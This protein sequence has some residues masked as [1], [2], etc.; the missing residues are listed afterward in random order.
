MSKHTFASSARAS[1]HHRRLLAALTPVAAIAIAVA[2]VLPTTPSDAAT[3]FGLGTATSFA[4]LAGSGITNPGPTTI[5]GDVGT[6]PTPA[7][8]GFGSVTLHGI[9]HADDAVTQGSKADLIGAYD[10]A[11]G[12]T[13][14]TTVPTELG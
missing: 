1:R 3:N 11:A 6:H 12:Q 4:V 5:T 2:V 8:T 7:E 13:S 14:V 9:N 10:N